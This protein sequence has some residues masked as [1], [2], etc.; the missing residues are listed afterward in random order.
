MEILIVGIMLVALMVYAS[1]RIKRVAAEAFDA[2]RVE[3]D[4]FL[5]DKPEG[6]LNV[7]NRN[8]SLAFDAYS[9]EF[10]ADHAASFRAARA[11]VRLLAG[12]KMN[13]AVAQLS[14]SSKVLSD[15][16]EVIDGRKY[17]VIEAESVEKG[18]GFREIYKLSENG[19]GV[20]EMKLK[21]VEGSDAEIV[22]KAELMLASFEIK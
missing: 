17:R 19:N 11:E 8:P 2:E 6:F 21:M 15:V 4:K 9:R 3:T 1:T 20:F 10:G 7:L 16:T 12:Q 5:V 22:K 18:V 14:R 13:D